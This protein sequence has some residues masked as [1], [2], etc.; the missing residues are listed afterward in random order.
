MSDLNDLFEQTKSVALDYLETLHERPVMPEQA[1]IQGLE[2]FK[3]PM[4]DSG[5]P[6]KE[7]ISKL[8]QHGSP[9]TVATQ[10]GRFY[11]FVQGSSLPV[12]VAANW[13][14]TAWDQ[15]AGTWV[16]SPVAAELENVA[17]DWLLD[18][19]DLPRDATIGF[20]TGATMAEF[21]SFAAAR[22]ALLGRLGYDLKKQGLR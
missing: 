11:G 8:H 15:N 17:S 5:S 6:A 1:A 16:L 12:S 10:G 9:A 20:V 2:Q 19:F 13:L 21:S 18:I 4:P 7:V 3:E 14:A 22:H